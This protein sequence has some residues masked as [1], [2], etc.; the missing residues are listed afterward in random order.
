[1]PYNPLTLG[2][3]TVL[4]IWIR[5]PNTD[6]EGSIEYRSGSET[7]LESVQETTVFTKYIFD[8]RYQFIILTTITVIL[9]L[10]N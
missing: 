10:E 9:H 6:L 4:R 7:L 3:N 1:M 5:I 2:Q 8:Y